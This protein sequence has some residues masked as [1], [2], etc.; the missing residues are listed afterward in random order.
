MVKLLSVLQTMPGATIISADE[1]YVHAEFRTKRMRFV[2]DF[3]ARI[4]ASESMIQVRSAS[5]VGKRDFNVNRDR[6]EAIRLAYL[7]H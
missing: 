3:E 4:D 5:R 7:N 6:V 2:D 1:A